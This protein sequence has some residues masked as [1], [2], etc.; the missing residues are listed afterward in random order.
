MR[1]GQNSFAFLRNFNDGG[2]SSKPPVGLLSAIPP[3]VFSK[4]F[5]YLLILGSAYSNW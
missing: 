1:K 4:E 2:F 3:V 5:D